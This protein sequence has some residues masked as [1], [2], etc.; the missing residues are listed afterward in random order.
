MSA[1]LRVVGEGAACGLAFVI[2]AGEALAWEPVVFGKVLGG[3]FVVASC[4]LA[5]LRRDRPVCPTAF[6]WLLGLFALCVVSLLWT[7]DSVATA[8]ASRHLMMEGALL[9]ALTLWPW[10]L[11]LL[12]RIAQGGG[13]GALFLAVALLWMFVSGEE[14]GF[15]IAVGEGDPNLQARQLGLGLLLGLG[16]IGGRGKE[17][18]SRRSWLCFAMALMAL[19]IGITGS[20]GAAVAVLGG[21]LAWGWVRRV[22]SRQ[23]DAGPRGRLLAGTEGVFALA[24]ALCVGLGLG[25][26]ALRGDLRSVVDTV[27]SGER[28]DWSSGRD[29]I[30]AN[31]F[32]LWREHPLLGVGAAAVPS[33]YDEVRDERMAEGGLHSKRARD[34]HS[35]FLQLLVGLGPLGL[36]FLLAA[37]YTALA[38][39]RGTARSELGLALWVFLALSALTQSTL[40][41]KD[42]W[43]GFAWVALWANPSDRAHTMVDQNSESA[44]SSGGAS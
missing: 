1:A 22:E 25:A 39:V 6:F 44:S 40:E 29:A 23:A 17:A 18:S 34:P 21:L 20:R 35:L 28:E 13:A 36:L 7:V 41:L 33:V 42:F 9:V 16:V 30:W 43:L 12:R 31:S 11:P 2:C 37:G 15:R 24:L 4:S 27:Q 32:D 5:L 19:A 26:T 3:A 8:R 14:R 10:R 38:A